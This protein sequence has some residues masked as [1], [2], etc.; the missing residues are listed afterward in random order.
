MAFDTS[1][2]DRALAEQAARWETERAALLDFLQQLLAEAAERFGL[3]SAYIFGSIVS[4]GRFSDLSDVDVAVVE[5]PAKSFFSLAAFLS[6]RL[7]R[8]VDL[9]WLDEV[10]FAPRIRRNGL[11]WTKSG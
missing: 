4:P 11:L 1:V 2:L 8:D 6:D 9:I 7:G 5:L 10:H 3:R